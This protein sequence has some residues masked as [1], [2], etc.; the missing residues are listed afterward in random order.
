MGENKD[1]S[2][3]EIRID[4]GS[5]EPQ[6]RSSRLLRGPHAYP[7]LREDLPKRGNNDEIL[8]YGRLALHRRRDEY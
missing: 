8:D 3:V 2:P 1:V 6:V 5:G 4:C 7:D